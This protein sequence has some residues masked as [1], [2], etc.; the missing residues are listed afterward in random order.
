MAGTLLWTCESESFLGED[1]SL[2]QTG[3]SKAAI[4]IH[5]EF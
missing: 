2:R 3:P 5:E 4:N 1:G